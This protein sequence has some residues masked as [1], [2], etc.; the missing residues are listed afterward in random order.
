M[1]LHRADARRRGS[2]IS[3]LVHPRN[4]Y[5][6]KGNYAV[7]HRKKKWTE[8]FSLSGNLK[9]DPRPKDSHQL[10]VSRT[11]RDIT[12][13]EGL[14]GKAAWPFAVSAWRA[15]PQPGFQHH[16]QGHMMLGRDPRGYYQ[17]IVCIYSGGEVGGRAALS[18][19]LKMENWGGEEQL[20]RAV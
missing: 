11:Q 20:A 16:S 12:T 1:A 7:R 8:I 14:H 17:K 6:G 3:V 18:V 19:F 13:E 2:L 9:A 5:I 15:S 4:I 10:L